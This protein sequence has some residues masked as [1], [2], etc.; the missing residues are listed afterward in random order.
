MCLATPQ[1]HHPPNQLGRYPRRNS[2]TT[3]V[4]ALPTTSPPLALPLPPPP[5]LGNPRLARLAMTLTM[6]LARP[7][8][9]SAAYKS[10]N[11]PLRDLQSRKPHPFPVTM[12][13][14]AEGLR[15]LRTIAANE[16]GGATA[17]LDL[18]RGMKNVVTRDAFQKEGG[19]EVA[20]T[21][22]TTSLKVA[23]RYAHSPH[24]LIFKIKTTSFMDR[25]VDLSFL[26]CFPEEC[27]HL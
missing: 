14:I 18:W 1:G 21:S 27:E 24:S 12:W 5:S 26:S 6:T 4:T 23:V 17:P 10:L 19:T 25:G 22:T 16:E 15:Q 8:R 2:H 7:C 9:R 13:L 20:P 3:L 11:A